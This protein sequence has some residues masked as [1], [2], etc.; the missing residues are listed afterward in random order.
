MGF[1]D[2]IFR[3]ADIQHI[4]EFLLNGVEAA[5]IN[6]KSYEQRIKESKQDMYDF[7]KVRYP[8]ENDFAE[9]T[10]AIFKYVNST[11]DVYMEIGLKC[12]A[13]LAMQSFIDVKN[14]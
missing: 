2:E 5:Q 7:F 1:T 4:R 6:D 12:G 10:A 14:K 13:V 9:I 8:D 11:E 3:R